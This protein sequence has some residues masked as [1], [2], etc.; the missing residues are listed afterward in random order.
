MV[1]KGKTPEEA[2]SG[3]KPKINHL[4]VFGFLVYVSIPDASYTKLDAKSQKLMLAR[5]SSLQKAYRLI[6]VETSRLI[7]SCDVVFEE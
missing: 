4:K 5:Y 6:Y 2:W 1:V 7:Y 3:C